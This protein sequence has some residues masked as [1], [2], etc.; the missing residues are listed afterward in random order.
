MYLIGLTGGIASGKSTIARRLTEHGAVLI[1]ADQLSREAVEP[2]T[3]ALATIVE[4]FGSGVL[5]ADGSL[6]RAALGEIVFS[7]PEALATLNAIVH[8]AVRSL[9]SK[10]IEDAG[11]ADPAA[12][13]VYDI[14]L[15]VESRNEYPFDLIVVAHASPATRMTRLTGIRGMHKAE[16]RKRIDAQAGDEER[17]AVADVVIDTEGNL[18]DTLTQADRLWDR[19]RTAPSR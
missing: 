1:D 10:R 8:P 4:R 13:V 17:L 3:P 15:L 6:D 14:P 5:N 12:V 2:G 19:V 16:A 7:D 11:N 18:E 9:S